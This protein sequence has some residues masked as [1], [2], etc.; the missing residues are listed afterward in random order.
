MPTADNQARELIAF[1][2]AG[3]EFRV[4][5]MAVRDIPGWTVATPLSRSPGCVG[6]VVK[7]HG[8]ALPMI[9]ML[10]HLGLV[11]AEPAKRRVHMIARARSQ[12]AG[13]PANLVSDRVAIGGSEARVAPDPG[14]RTERE[15]ARGL[16][17][18]QGRTVCPVQHDA[19]YCEHE[20]EAA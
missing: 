15:F 14:D 16:V 20:R 17:P 3:Q 1:E 9:D 5:V 11:A 10:P 19:P 7:V 8:A 6:G 12:I 4:D 18:L 13:L 2:I